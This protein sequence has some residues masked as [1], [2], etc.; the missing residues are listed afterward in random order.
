MGNPQP[1]HGQHGPNSQLPPPQQQKQKG[2]EVQQQ[3]QQQQQQQQQ[4]QTPQVGTSTSSLYYNLGALWVVAFFA[5]YFC[6]RGGS[7]RKH[8]YMQVWTPQRL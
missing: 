6:R 5:L 4:Q 8:K 1:K 7:R 3:L 2:H